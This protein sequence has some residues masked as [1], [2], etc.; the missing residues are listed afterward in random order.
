ME[1]ILDK[2]L[3]DY[4]IKHSKERMQYEYDRFGLS[5]QSRFD[6]VLIGTI[7]QLAFKKHLDNLDITYS[8]EF[9]AGEY[10]EIDFEIN[11]EIIEIKTSGYE[12][13]FNH[14]NMLYNCDQYERGKAKNYKYCVQVFINGY[15]RARK[16]F[17]PLDCN[18]AT[19][20]GIIKFEDIK[21]HPIKNMNYA[22]CYVV[23]L[24]SLQPITE[25]I[26][27]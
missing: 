12:H 10:D 3:I 5:Q 24:N 23:P 17:N 2:A 20:A 8:F 16:V 15:D 4:A 18:K 13:S 9:Q 1:I 21:K 6:M 27:C 11:T 14:L 26:K 22:F 7:G 25:V 19:I